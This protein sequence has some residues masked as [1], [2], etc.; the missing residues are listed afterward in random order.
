MSDPKKVFT[1]NPQQQPTQRRLQQ[2]IE[3]EHEEEYV[4]DDDDEEEDDGL[5]NSPP[6]PPPPLISSVHQ[7]LPERFLDM[8]FTDASH[9]LSNGRNGSQRRGILRSDSMSSASIPD[10]TY[11]ADTSVHS[12]TTQES[13]ELLKNLEIRLLNA[14][15]QRRRIFGN[16]FIIWLMERK[17]SL[18]LMNA[19]YLFQIIH[20]RLN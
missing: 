6:P 11:I 18:I 13:K 14:S 3:E 9:L 16:L 20:E 19:H 8:P 15:I 17:T 10:E 12:C 1:D 7:K 5:E 2:G 4:E